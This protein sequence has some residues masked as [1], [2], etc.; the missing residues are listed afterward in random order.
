MKMELDLRRR[1]LSTEVR[2]LVQVLLQ[3]VQAQALL[4]LALAQVLLQRV[5]AQVLLRLALAQVLPQQVQ[6]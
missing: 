2:L 1:Q 4:R 3:R 5:Q 6:E